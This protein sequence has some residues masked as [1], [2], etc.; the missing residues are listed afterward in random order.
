MK[1]HPLFRLHP[2]LAAVIIAVS[3][4]ALLFALYGLNRWISQGEVMGRVEVG[5]TYLGGL[6]AE[7]A[8]ASLVGLEEALLD[9]PAFFTIDNA[10]V[11]LSPRETGLDLDEGYL[12]D[13]VMAV[14]REGNV[15]YQFLW[16][17]SHIFKTEGVPVAAST[18]PEAISDVFDA[19]DAEVIAQPVS[20]GAVVLEEGVPTPV[21]PRSGMGLDRAM[22]TAIVEESLLAEEPEREALPTTVLVPKLTDADIDAAV[23]EAQ[24]LLASP[25]SLIY[26]DGRVE[27]SPEQLIAA[28]VATTVA[29]GSPQIVHSFDPEVIDTYLDPIRADYEAEPVDARFAID[30]DRISIVPGSKG[31]RI[32]EAEAAQKLLQAGRSS[33]RIGVLPL[34]EDADPDTTTEELEALGIEHL[35]SSFTTYHSCCEDRVVNIQKMADTIDMA[36]VRSGQQFSINEYVGQRTEEKGYLPAGTI[37]AGELVDTVGGGVSQFATTLYNAVY[38]GGYEDVEHKPHS[39]YFSRYPE[40]IEGTVNWR[41][42]DLIFRNNTSKAILIDTQHTD[43]SITVRIFGDNDG[44]TVKG[45]QRSGSTNVGAVS[46]GGPDALHIASTVSERFAVQPPPPPRYV[47][48]PAFPVD[49]VV[50]KQTER[51]GWSV[52]VTRRILRGGTELVSEQTWTATYIPQGLIYEVHP[53]KVPGQEHTCPT[54]TTLGSTTTTSESPTT[55]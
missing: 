25:I 11:M 20:L 8:L 21:Y 29:E 13:R 6:P 4:F 54:T 43:S 46:R 7:E 39:Y 49:K 48:N 16:W 36:I 3:V 52:N 5:G 34:I 17:L 53:C 37:I 22:A 31:T 33:A 51:E 24:A 1:N 14:G 15:S 45:E 27:F 26:Q 19:W 47:V 38:W 41:T 9:R 44:R 35:V 30:G 18:D 12:L 40:G 2:L 10:P 23:I 28:Y 32:D 55:S 50:T 42:P